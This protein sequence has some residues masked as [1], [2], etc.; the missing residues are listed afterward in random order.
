M[1]Q[2]KPAGAAAR[3]MPTA[4]IRTIC[5]CLRSIDRPSLLHAS[6]T[7]TGN[8][9]ANRTNAYCYRYSAPDTRVSTKSNRYFRKPADI[10]RRPTRRRPRR[11]AVAIRCGGNS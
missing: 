8:A 10:F 4:A 7:A 5:T 1:G 6:M 2:Q 11:D 9:G 3:T